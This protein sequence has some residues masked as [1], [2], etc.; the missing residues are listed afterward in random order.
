MLQKNQKGYFVQRLLEILPGFVSWNLILFPVWGAFVSPMAVAYFVLLF[1]IFWFYKS[2]TFAFFAIIAHLRI[3]ASQKMDWLGELKFF[4]DWKKVHHFVIIC[5]YKEPLYIL[6]RTL[7][8]LLDQTMPKGQI[9]IIIGFE[10]REQG[11]QEKAEAIKK[12]FGN[13]FA[14]L[15]ISEHT[16]VFGETAGKHSNARASIL[17]AK[18]E[19]IDTQKI[20]ADYCVVSSCDADH[21]YHPNYFANLTYNFLDNPHRFSRFW[22]PAIVYYNNFWRL[23]AISRVANTFGTIWDMAQLVRTDR[24]LN[25]ASYSL[26]FRLLNQIGFWDQDVIPEDW[27]MFFK[28]FFSSGGKVEVEPIFLPLSA[29][30]AESTN[31]FNTIKNQYQQLKRWAWGVSDT[32]YV[33]KNY[34]LSRDIPFW[35]KTLR[36]LR[37]I[38]DHFLW[39]VN[40][41]IIT[42]GVN[43]PTFVNK[44]FAKT[45]LGF[46]LPKTSSFILTLCLISLGVIIFIDS[47]H[48]PPRPKE[49]SRLRALLVPFEFILMPLSGFIFGALPGLD[50]HTRLMLGKYMEYRVTE[51]KQRV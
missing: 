5:T 14:H 48:R 47:R 27:H 32:P 31:F 42:L 4:P 16:L 30:A 29:D 44:N 8:S 50:A 45:A 3:E 49:V 24:L 1:D 22:Q 33:L 35:D 13:K 19:L 37:F 12:M 28:A 18:K 41:F 7:Q 46:N 34:L 40:W 39:P 2:I 23:P 26:S 36:T 9:S 6:E 51:I 21:L 38:E 17:L 11:W 15:L 20:E 43:I 10:S 25:L